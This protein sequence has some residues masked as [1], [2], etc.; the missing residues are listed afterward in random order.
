MAQRL[1]HVGTAASARASDARRALEARGVA[2]V[3]LAIGEP[4]FPTPDH[5]IA[6]AHEAALRGETRYPPTTGTRHLKDAVIAA[7]L[8]NNGLHF[9]PE[10]IIVCTGAKQAIFNALCA[11]IDQGDTVVISPPAY[12]SYA[13]IVALFGGKVV[14]VTPDAKL[15]LTPDALAQAPGKTSRWLILNNPANPSGVCY[16]K[17]ELQ[18]FGRVLCDFPHVMIMSDEIYEHIIFD[19]I[20]FTAVATACPD[21]APRTL[22]VNGVSKAYAMTGWR[23]GYAAGD[24][25]LIAAMAKIQSQATSG[26]TSVAQAA[27][28]AAL[29]GPQTHIPSWVKTWQHRRDMAMNAFDTMQGLNMHRP[30]GAFYGFVDCKD[31]LGTIT[32]AGEQITTCDAFAKYLLHQAH[33]SVV[34]GA[35]YGMPGFIRISFACADDDLECGL[36]AIKRASAALR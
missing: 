1:A 29:N 24:A 32:P 23:I 13:D 12:A 5:V 18:E 17:A 3:N 7:F 19:Q 30:E 35:A 22:T 2:I 6:A 26:A 4:D 20:P 10:N 34:A 27:A 36:A 31:L 21:L 16:T 33:V 15:R 28:A 14:Y 8:R 9:G 11:T 25:G